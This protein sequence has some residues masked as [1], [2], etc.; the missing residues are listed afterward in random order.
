MWRSCD[1]HVHTTPNERDPSPFE[2]EGFVA[3]CLS[4]GLE[5]VAVTD[6]DHL[7]RLSEVIDAAAASA[8]IV[9][10]GVE[11]STDRGH[12]LA[13]APGP[14]GEQAM[15]EFCA[16]TGVR[17]GSQVPFATATDVVRNEQRKNGTPYNE[18]I[19]L[20][21]SHVETGGS[22]LATQQALGVEAQIRAASQV[23]ALEVADPAVREQ[24]MQSGV[25]Q[26][27][28]QFTFVQ[29]SDAHSLEGIGSTATH[30]YLPQ[31]DV[32]SLRH[33]LATPEASV[34]FEMPPEPPGMHIDSVSFEGGYF[35][36]VSIEFCERANAIIG[37][38][39]SG[40]SFL[41]DALRFAF[42]LECP[43]DEIAR[44]CAS[45]LEQCLPHG[46]TVRVRCTVNGD[47]FEVER[48]VGASEDPTP[49]FIP[50]IFS[51][52][53]LSR[54]AMDPRPSM[55]LLDVHV[56]SA[57]EHKSALRRLA[58]K[59]RGQFEDLLEMASQ[60][61]EL[62]SGVE[63]TV[64]GLVVTKAAI[65]DLAGTE[66][67]AQLAM[68]VSRTSAWRDR[69]RELVSEWAAS[70]EAPETPT[71][72]GRPKL[73]T[74]KIPGALFIQAE[75]V[76]ALHEK[77]RST[78]ADAAERLRDELIARLDAGDA[79]FAELEEGTKENLAKA[80]FK[81]GRE[82][83]EELRA[84]RM[85]LVALEQKAD[86]LGQL[87]SKID[88][89]LNELRGS[90]EAVGVAREGLRESRKQACRTIN[91]SMRTFFAKL[92]LD[93]QTEQ[94]DRL[95]EDA[96]VGTGMWATSLSDIR[97]RLD[98]VR[99]LEFA[100]RR[101]QGRLERL[102]PAELDEQDRIVDAALQRD[103]VATLAKIA[104][105]YAGDDL[106]LALH[107]DPP[108]PFDRLTEGMRALA[109]KE[110]S[111]AA[112]SLPVITDQPEDAVPTQAVFES[113]VPTLRRQRAERQ[114]IVAS[115]DA[116]I[117]V[118]GDIERIL[119]LDP[120]A[121]VRPGTL[122]DEDVRSAALNLLEGGRAAFETR[123]RRYGTW[124]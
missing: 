77:F 103:K 57:A 22:L 48:T 59:V 109:I 79:P 83:L 70:V 31:V 69:V 64:D 49:P 112:S 99:V 20:I 102:P 96:K 60:A 6:H 113:L 27:D 116:N 89:G 4:A 86:A 13:L 52:N 54:R 36:G 1:L 75:D 26:Q 58:K 2:A 16:R 100:V 105:T 72:P 107:G 51:Q 74:D 65:D 42:G 85:R 12:V 87:D 114:F 53:E 18:S 23:Q 91:A 98:R 88:S 55:A 71:L 120:S 9:I 41:I 3:A 62:A 80:G 117:V 46:A 108:T 17:A 110:I 61:Q 95:L 97:E 63:N 38:P 118:A 115:H 32:T 92:E 39:N 5:V 82:V 33:A 111:F 93:H 84:Q 30:F 81:G 44:I 56:P 45:R 15:A 19:I 90:V 119:V 123:G 40:K 67:A 10:A 28:G 8:L 94:I 122:F 121:G 24:W 106:E 76:T 73:D 68:D 21:G 35:D 29:F 34:R 50:I 66:P 7:D 101:Q 11:I 78:V 14:E 47:R 37:P 124:Q 43:I 25:K 104:T